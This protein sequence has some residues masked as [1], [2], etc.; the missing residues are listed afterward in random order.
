MIIEKT[1]WQCSTCGK[2]INITNGER[3]FNKHLST[4]NNPLARNFNQWYGEYFRRDHGICVCR[5]CEKDFFHEKLDPWS[6]LQYQD[7]LEKEHN[8]IKNDL[9]QHRTN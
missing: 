3:N 9:Y 7:H 1:F 6:N 2:E 4:H 8:I 5:L